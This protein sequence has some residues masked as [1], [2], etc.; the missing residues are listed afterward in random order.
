MS[1]STPRTDVSPKYN[2]ERNTV[3]SVDESKKFFKTEIMDKTLEFYNYQLIH[4]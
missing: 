1:G 2:S 3:P 4:N